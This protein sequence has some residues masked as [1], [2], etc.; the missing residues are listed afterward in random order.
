M[1]IQGKKCILIVVRTHMEFLFATKIKNL[2]SSH[3]CKHL[4]LISQFQI[5]IDDDRNSTILHIKKMEQ[6]KAL[7]LS[8]G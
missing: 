6:S 3:C 5:S 8:P 1:W 7:C 2:F 4:V